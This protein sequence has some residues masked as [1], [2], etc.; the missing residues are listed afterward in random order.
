MLYSNVGVFGLQ[1]STWFGLLRLSSE[2]ASFNSAG[3]G[4]YVNYFKEGAELRSP[5]PAG[6]VGVGRDWVYSYHGRSSGSDHTLLTTWLEFVCVAFMWVK[7]FD[8]IFGYVSV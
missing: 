6:R 7:N 3:L 2:S 8:K 1:C 4:R 5:R